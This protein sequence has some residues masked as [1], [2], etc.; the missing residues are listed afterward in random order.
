MRDTGLGK[1]LYLKYQFTKSGCN[2]LKTMLEYLR[3]SD[4][5]AEELV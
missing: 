2:D 1:Q 5:T 3:E 4:E